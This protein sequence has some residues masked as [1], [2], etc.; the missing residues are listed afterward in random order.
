M[1]KPIVILSI[2]L[3]VLLLILA[4]TY[5]IEPANSLPHFIPGYQA[6]LMKHHT[7][8]AIGS[9]LLGLALFAFAWFQSGKK[10]SKQK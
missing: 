1:N 5:F 4:G 9:L 3:G 8:H 10:S 7:T 6:G 2:V